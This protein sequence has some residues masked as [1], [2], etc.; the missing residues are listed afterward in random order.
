MYSTASAS[1][2]VAT[3]SKLPSALRFLY[4]GS[5]T[6]FPIV[7]V[8]PFTSTVMSPGSNLVSLKSKYLSSALTV[9]VVVL[10]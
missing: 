5:L 4:V 9:I 7:D 10:D 3:V 8:C 2:A 1:S 6:S